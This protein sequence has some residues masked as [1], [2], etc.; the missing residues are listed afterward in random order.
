MVVHECQ[1]IRMLIQ[2]LD[3]AL[4]IKAAVTSSIWTIEEWE[5]EMGKATK[6]VAKFVPFFIL[7]SK[8]IFHQS[9]EPQC[10]LLM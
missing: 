7:L 6:S 8:A 2:T 1:G 4:K 10:K 5:L 9:L 3:R